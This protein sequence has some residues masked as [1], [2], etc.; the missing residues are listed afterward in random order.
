MAT[1][2]LYIMTN[3]EHGS[4]YVGSTSD[5]AARLNEHRSGKGSKHV[6]KYNLFRVVYFQAYE[7]KDT[8]LVVEHRVKRKR[9]DYKIWLVEQA[10]P[11]WLD[12]TQA[13]LAEAARETKF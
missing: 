2:W 6:W 8:A 13:W 9:R 5:P 7:D 3:K 11:D 10:N 1:N 12:L 4:F